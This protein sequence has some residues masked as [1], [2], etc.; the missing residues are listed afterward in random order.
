[1]V[2]RQ[3]VAGRKDDVVKLVRLAVGCCLKKSGEVLLHC[4]LVAEITNM[5]GDK[6]RRFD[7]FGISLFQSGG[8][9]A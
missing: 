1:M 4:L 8:T 6:A 3:G 7:A 5:A 2:S 9:G